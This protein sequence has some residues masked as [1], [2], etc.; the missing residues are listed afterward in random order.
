[1]IIKLILFT[2]ETYKRTLWL[3]RGCELGDLK[4]QCWSVFKKPG[5]GGVI[6]R[7]LRKTKNNKMFYV[8]FY[9]LNPVI[10]HD[11]YC[12]IPANSPGSCIRK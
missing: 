8:V 4:P 12:D 7:K 5:A 3:L 1:L 10:W 2:F 6:Y 9:Y 11:W